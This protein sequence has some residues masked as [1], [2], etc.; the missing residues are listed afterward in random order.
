[1]KQVEVPY[2]FVSEWG[3]RRPL[4]RTWGGTN[5]RPLGS[6]TYA[7]RPSAP[8]FPEENLRLMK[9]HFYGLNVFPIIKLRVSKHW[10]NTNHWSQPVACP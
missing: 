5:P 8:P 6:D 7:S 3:G 9:R 10:M 2:G 4:W 1:V